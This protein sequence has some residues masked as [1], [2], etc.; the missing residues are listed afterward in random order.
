MFI[1][2]QIL[3]FL[4]APFL[5]GCQTLVTPDVRHNMH[6]IRVEPI[7]E[8]YGHKMRHFLEN[9][10]QSNGKKPLYSLHI[11]LETW[12][13][14]RVF[15]NSGKAIVKAEK[16]HVHYTLKRIRDD[17]ILLQSSKKIRGIRPFSISP[18][19]QTIAMEH[20]LDQSLRILSYDIVRHIAE[21]L[22]SLCHSTIKP[23]SFRP[24]QK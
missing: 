24:K 10:M 8:H 15:S 6:C 14:T 18:Y 19:A 16:S 23:Q 12:D 13:Q 20:Q 7:A 17:K 3:V 11:T 1:L 9:L 22:H 5:Q 21:T 4:I 2:F